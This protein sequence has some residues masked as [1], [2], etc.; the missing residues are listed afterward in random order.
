MK[1]IDIVNIEKVSRIFKS[2][3]EKECKGVSGLYYRLSHEVSEDNDLLRLALNSRE[4]QPVPNL[5]FG[6]IHYLL[7]KYPGEELSNYYPS[8]SKRVSSNIPIKLI[9][10]FCVRRKAEILE[11]LKD[12]IVQTNAIN[13]TSYLMPIVFSRFDPDQQ[14]NL[15]DIG[16]SSG[17]TLNFEKY[18][19]DYGNNKIYGDSRVKIKTKILEGN[20]P[21]FNER[22]S[23][24]RKIGIDQNPLD[25]TK[26]DNARWLK[27]LIWP[28]LQARFERLESAIELAKG[29]KLELY[30]AGDPKGFKEIIDQVPVSEGLMIYHTHVLYQFSSEERKGFREMLDKLGKERDYKYLAVEANAVFDREDDKSNGIKIELTEYQEGDKHTGTIGETDGHA[31]W[32]K[33]K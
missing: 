15:I 16:T 29:S 30:K 21:K 7:L 8:I 17:L 32:I 12:R 26:E 5:F 20:L 10:E 18:E 13:R 11:V 23:V 3:A 14:I 24:K 31:N 28:D 22:L 4:R 6:S 33:W 19:Y 27:S 9:K 2:F 1:A 25:L